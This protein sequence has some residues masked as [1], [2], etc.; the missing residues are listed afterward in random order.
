MDFKLI[1]E[2]DIEDDHPT[3]YYFLFL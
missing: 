3:F 1:K 2:P